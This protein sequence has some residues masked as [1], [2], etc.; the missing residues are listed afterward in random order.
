MDME[1]YKFKDLKKELTPVIKRLPKYARLIKVLSI[2]THLSFAQK[3]TLKAALGYMAMPFDLIPDSVPLLGRLDDTFA[4]FFAVNSVL[5][6]LTPERVD[7][8]LRECELTPQIVASD[9]VV[10]RNAS[11][12]LAKITAKKSTNVVN[13]FTSSWRRA[14]SKAAEEFRREYKR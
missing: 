7:E 6:T 9:Q 10:V 12:N 1:E 14:F 2:D 11:K 5:K 13:R 4:G 8:V 3:T